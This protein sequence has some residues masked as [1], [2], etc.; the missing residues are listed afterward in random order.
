MMRWLRLWWLR[1]QYTAAQRFVDRLEMQG[2]THS[3]LWQH[4][5][6]RQA[7]IG[8]RIIALEGE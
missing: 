3:L 8:D 4:A 5:V 6:R 1:R 2:V 7:S